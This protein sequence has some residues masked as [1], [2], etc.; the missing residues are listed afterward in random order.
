[1]LDILDILDIL[2]LQNGYTDEKIME[3]AG[4]KGKDTYAKWWQGTKPSGKAFGKLLIEA[5]KLLPV[6]FVCPLGVPTE[7]MFRT[8]C[9]SHVIEFIKEYP[10]VETHTSWH[11]SWMKDEYPDLYK[12]DW[13]LFNWAKQQLEKLLK[14]KHYYELGWTNKKQWNRPH[15]KI[16][17]IEKIATVAN[18]HPDEHIRNHFDK[19]RNDWQDE[20][21]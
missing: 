19:I 18:W 8:A 6:E 3:I 14:H 5:R 16:D 2:H 12:I 20:K 4:I 1:M 17:T 13:Q 7:E 9:E 21:S 15:Y 10:K 11:W